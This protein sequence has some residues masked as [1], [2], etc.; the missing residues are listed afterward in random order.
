MVRP[1]FGYAVALLVMVLGNV[2]LGQELAK[3]WAWSGIAAATLENQSGPAPAPGPAPSGTCETCNGS[4]KVGDGRVFQI[5]KD[6]NGTGKLTAAPAPA[7]VKPKATAA[8]PAPIQYMQVCI[9][10]KCQWV[11]VEQPQQAPSKQDKPEVICEGGVCYPVPQVQ[12]QRYQ[13]RQPARVI[14]RERGF[15]F[16]R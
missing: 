7:P 14:M 1:R 3:G 12:Q 6:C 13:T 10:G 4:G 9:N 8:A 5:C 2:A 11:P 16:R 15:F